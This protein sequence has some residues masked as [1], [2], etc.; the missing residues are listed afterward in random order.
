M[1]DVELLPRRVALY[2]ALASGGDTKLRVEM[3]Q[4]QEAL[5]A[6]IGAKARSI[7]KDFIA[8]VDGMYRQFKVPLRM[9][10]NPWHDND[11]NESKID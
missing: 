6:D 10:I 9:V 8:E 3:R 7:Q 1:S 11:F 2:E 5:F 4:K